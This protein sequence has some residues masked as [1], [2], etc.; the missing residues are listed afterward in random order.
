MTIKEL[1]EIAPLA[2]VYE[3]K[4]DAKYIAFVSSRVFGMHEMMKT[5][6]T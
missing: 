5:L 2:D 6:S 1:K 4:P 3:L